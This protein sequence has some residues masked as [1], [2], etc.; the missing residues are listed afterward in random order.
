MEKLLAF[1]KCVIQLQEAYSYL[2]SQTGSADE[3]PV[4][5]DMPPN[6]TIDDVLMQLQAMK[7]SLTEMLMEL[8]DS[9]KRP[10]YMILNQKTAQGT[11]PS[12]TN[13]QVSNKG[14]NDKVTRN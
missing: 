6:D 11:A 13:N 5:S 8:A 12:G 7:I 3:T 14:M 10:L 2:L 4:Y 1:Q 9:A